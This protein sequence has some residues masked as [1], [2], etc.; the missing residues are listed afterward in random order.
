MPDDIIDLAKHQREEHDR[1]L[2]LREIFLAQE[3]SE[4]RIGELPCITRH[5]T[6]LDGILAEDPLTDL[7]P[8][9]EMLARAAYISALQYKE[10][11][12]PLIKQLLQLSIRRHHR[13]FMKLPEP[14]RE[15]GAWIWGEWLDVL[16]DEERE[17]KED[18]VD[19]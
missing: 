3:R 19:A 4:M 5:L 17:W 13:Q 6:N 15:A 2:H 11:P 8:R 18:T 10:E 16:N 9:V 14:V 12:E 1:L 7:S